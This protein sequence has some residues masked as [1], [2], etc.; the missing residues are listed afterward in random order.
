MAKLEELE[1][2]DL[3]GNKLKAVPTTIM[4]CRRMHTVTAHSNCIEVFPEVMQLPEIKVRGQVRDPRRQAADV[5]PV[6]H[7][8][9]ILAPPGSPWGEDASVLAPSSSLLGHTAELNEAGKPENKKPYAGS[10]EGGSEA[11]SLPVETLEAGK[12]PCR[13]ERHPL[14]CSCLGPHGHRSL[15]GY[16]PWGHEGWNTTCDW[17]SAA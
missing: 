5:L 4:S 6:S 17:T 16:C 9:W 12:T 15:V 7:W 10:G 11:K 13:R 2:I 14:Q 3:S 8:L 1:E